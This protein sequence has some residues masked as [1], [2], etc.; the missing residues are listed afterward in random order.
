MRDLTREARPEVGDSRAVLLGGAVF[1]AVAQRRLQPIKVGSRDIDLLIDDDSGG[2]L[3][4]SLAHET[5]LAVLDRETFLDRDGGNL[6]LE[7]ADR[8][9]EGFVS[10]EDQVVGVAL[11]WPRQRLKGQP[12]GA[13]RR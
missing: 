8:A 1:D 5:G 12:G 4:D 6:H 10:G 11:S 2:A 9:G 7:P 13:S 3:T